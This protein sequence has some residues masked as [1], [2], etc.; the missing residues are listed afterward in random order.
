M[1]SNLKIWILLLVFGT[2]SM[3]VRA[4]ELRFCIHSEPKTFNPLLVDDDAS[5]T[6][7]YLT[8]GVLVRVNRSTQALEPGLAT[9]WKVSKDARTITFTLREQIYF[10]DGTPF[11]AEDVAVTVQRLMDPELHSPTGDSF[12]S[13]TGKTITQ[14]LDKKH[15]AITFPAPVAGLD[16]LFDQVAI[17]SA[18]SPRKE[19]SVLGPYYVA[20]HK[21]GSY[22]LLKRNPNYWKHDSLGRPLP[23]IDT[24]RLDIQPNRDIEVLR[25]QRGEIH[26]INSVDA[27]YYDRLAS[28]MPGAVHDGGPSFDTEQIWFN[29]VSKAPLPAYKLAW[30]R[31]MNFRRAV[32]ESINREDIARVAFGRHARPALGPVSPADKVW[33]N[34]KLRPIPHDTS[35]A[36]RLLKADGF[37]LK[38]RTL[39]DRN[40][41][42]VEF[43]IITNSGNK[44]RERMAVMIQQDLAQVGMKVNVVTLDFPSLIDRIAEKFNYEA[45]ILGFQNAETDPMAQMNVWLSSGNNHQWNPEQKSPETKWEAEIDRLMRAQASALGIKQRIADWDRVQEIVADQLPFIYLINKNALSV[46]SPSLHGTQPVALRPQTYWNIDRLYFDNTV[47]GAPK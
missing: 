9:A 12:R 36:L 21:S 17:L 26:L 39:V 23:Y 7:R 40:N 4:A 27:E 13:S 46:I 22:V 15:V 3:N 5:E 45:A 38:N 16:R 37:Q 25:F 20:D 1:S 10:S 19:M 18:H 11:S 43:S 2:L 29:Q 8:G 41:H 32:S 47:G 28:S 14:I 44:Y 24:V 6:I 34:A 35:D 42:P 31:S 33:F 30:F